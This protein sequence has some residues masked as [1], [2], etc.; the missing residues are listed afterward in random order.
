MAPHAGERAPLQE[1]GDANA[2]PVMDREFLDIE[3][4]AVCHKQKSF[5]ETPLA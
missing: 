1:Y 3:D 5:T 2:W 4:K